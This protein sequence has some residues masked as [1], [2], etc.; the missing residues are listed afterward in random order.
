[1]RRI[2]WAT[3]PQQT[4]SPSRE[5]AVQDPGN[6]SDSILPPGRQAVQQWLAQ[7]YPVPTVISL[8][9]AARVF[10]IPRTTLYR[11][12]REAPQN[13]VPIIRFHDRK[14]GINPQAF[15]DWLVRGGPVTP[16]RTEVA[17]HADS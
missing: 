1:M 2:V 12:A 5:A 3:S 10:H 15:A 4:A 14:F 13:G 11:L 16:V 7:H 6:V 8:S 17:P 9:E